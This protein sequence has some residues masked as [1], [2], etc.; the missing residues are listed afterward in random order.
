MD[1]K[2][3]TY[4]ST[5]LVVVNG[6]S[7]MDQAFAVMNQ[8]SVRHLPVVDDERKIVGIISDRDFLR[9]MRMDPSK[10]SAERAPI[11]EFDRSARVR[12]FM[13]WPVATMSDQ[14]T[15]GE[16]AQFMMNQ[17]I[18]A[19]LL[20]S[21]DKAVGIVTTED[22]LRALLEAIESPTEKIKREFQ[23]VILRLPVGQVAHTLS[24]AG[25]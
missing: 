18:S 4:A 3:S 25:I 10:F 19:L 23:D 21:V 2:L 11:G 14:Q 24:T 13:S 1:R 16:A 5:Q 9:A 15:I 22:L 6:N 7:A 17:K 8:H 12:D 20:T